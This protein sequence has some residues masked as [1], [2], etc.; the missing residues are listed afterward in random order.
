MWL[1]CSPSQSLIWFPVIFFL[2]RVQ[3]QETVSV[4]ILHP[5]NNLN[6]ILMFHIPSIFRVIFYMFIFLHEIHVYYLICWTTILHQMRTRTCLQT[7]TVVSYV[8]F[9]V[10][11][12]L[13]H[14]FA[15]ILYIW[16]YRERDCEVRKLT[17]NCWSATSI[18]N[19]SLINCQKHVNRSSYPSETF[20]KLKNR[21]YKLFL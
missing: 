14:F 9:L 15:K 8:I 7:Y 10:S 17:R 4:P 16:Q 21:I 13:N 19:R 3:V 18:I 2:Q 5:G 6:L 11:S 1:N 20:S 12:A